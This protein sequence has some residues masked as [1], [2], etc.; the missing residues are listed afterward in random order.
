MMIVMMIGPAGSGKSTLTGAYA[1]RLESELGAR[2]FKV[3][4]DPAAEYIPYTPDY[5]VRR[6][7]DARRVA[8]EYDLGP[9]GALVKSMGILAERLD[10]PVRAIEDSGA[11]YVIVDTP[12]QMEVFL[13]RD[14]SVRLARALEPVSERLCSLFILDATAI[15]EPPDYAFQLL[16]AVAASLRLDLEVAPVLN[17]AD[18]MPASLQA[19]GDLRSGYP[20]LSKSLKAHRSLYAEMLHELTRRT[21]FYAKRVRIPT[22]S[23]LK[24]EGLDDLH[25]LV[26]EMQCACGD[27]T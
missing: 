12:G 14:V 19:T 8:L 16:L 18:L 25:R 10:E 4:L 26:L 20:W 3:N 27:L 2:V 9:N 7:V 21:L 5:D 13:F 11:D 15:K 1:R 17:K 6:V 24:G 22:V 23:A